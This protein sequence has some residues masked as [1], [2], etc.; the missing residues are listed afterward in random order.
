MVTLEQMRAS[1]ARIAT[2][3]PPGL[4]A[5]FVGATSGIG[6]TT[7]KQFASRAQQPRIYFVGRRQAEGERTQAE[8]EKLNPDGGVPLHQ[9]G[10][11]SIA[12][13]RRG[14]P[15][16]PKPRICHQS[17]LPHLRVLDY[18]EALLWPIPET[19]EG[20]HYPMALMYYARTRFILNLLPQLKKA[21]SL[22]R[23]VT[24]GASGKEGP[25]IPSDWQANTLS[26]LSFRPH[27]ASMTTLSLLA[28]AKKEA[29]D[30]SFLHVYPGFVKTGMSRELTGLVPALARVLLAP[31]MALLQ[32]P[33]DE[34]GER[35]LYFATSARFPPGRS[36]DADGIM[37]G[38]GVGTAT[39]A[40]GA[41]GGGVYSID[42]EGEGTGGNVRGVLD[43]LVKDGTA[44]RLSE[45]TGE[46]FRR[47]TGS[48]AI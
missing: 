15:L 9:T 45:H 3:L 48:A 27:A 18:Q 25:I 13:R 2:T 35:Q 17:T 23:V 8:L 20:L 28:V 44:D 4:V 7:L 34:T 36:E 31:A 47:I 38:Q 24:V 41:L 39:G 1:N 37:L 6:N 11:Q 33:L 10:R 12:K 14:L 32:I 21:P 19:A 46:D 22:R 30:V 5:V 40:D 29:P 26:I 42:Y 43:A 16:Y